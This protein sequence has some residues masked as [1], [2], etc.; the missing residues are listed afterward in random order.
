MTDRRAT[1]RLHGVK[2]VNYSRQMHI[3]AKHLTRAASGWKPGEVGENLDPASNS[4]GLEAVT[5]RGKGGIEERRQTLSLGDVQVL[6]TIMVRSL[7]TAE[8]GRKARKG[9]EKRC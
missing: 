8:G 6:G 5:G 9:C 7:V 4:A 1:T 3:A 2:L